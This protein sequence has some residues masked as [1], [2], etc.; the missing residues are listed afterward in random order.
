VFSISDEK[1]KH[2]MGHHCPVYMLKLKGAESVSFS[3]A[4]MIDT[5]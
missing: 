5:Q 2:L 4:P 3:A 1:D